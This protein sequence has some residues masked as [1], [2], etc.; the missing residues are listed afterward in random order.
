M[1]K[2]IS[3]TGMWGVEAW[4][5]VI[6]WVAWVAW[7]ACAACAACVACAVG[8]WLRQARQAPTRNHPWAA[9][10]PRASV[11]GVWYADEA[12]HTGDL[13][14]LL[15][16][17]GASVGMVVMHSETGEPW[18]VEGGGRLTTLPMR[19]RLLAHE[20]MAIVVPILSPLSSTD[21]HRA[22]MR[23]R[24]TTAT[25][26][27]GSEFVTGVLA[28]VGIHVPRASAAHDLVR[29]VGECGG[30]LAPLRLS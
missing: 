28:K 30:Y 5:A 9:L 17:A 1:A 11:S 15:T 2:N 26:G 18:L 20:G 14:F 3:A 10:V 27:D 19:D 23:V 12:S 16:C 29:R 24:D 7:V 6:A 25:D 8:M 21:V 22:M 13:V 4:D